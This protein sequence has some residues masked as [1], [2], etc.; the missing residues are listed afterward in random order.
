MLFTLFLNDL[1][2]ATSSK[3]KGI[4]VRSDVVHTLLYADDLVLVAEAPEGLQ[5]QLDILK[6][7]ADNIKI[8]VNIDK[9]KVMVLRK[10]KRKFQLQNTWLLGEQEQQELFI[11][12]S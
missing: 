9:T 2:A 3:A 4:S 12:I 7:F 8:K 5:T 1:N 6:A 10:N 11:Q